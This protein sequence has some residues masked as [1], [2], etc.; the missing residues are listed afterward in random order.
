MCFIKQLSKINTVNFRNFMRYPLGC[1]NNLKLWRQVG[2]GSRYPRA[3][4]FHNW[5]IRT[6]WKKNSRYAYLISWQKKIPLYHGSQRCESHFFNA[7]LLIVFVLCQNSPK[8]KFGQ[9]GVL[10]SKNTWTLKSLHSIQC[11]LSS[12]NFN[13]KSARVPVILEQ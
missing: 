2:T 6:K 12:S 3:I 9:I 7:F 4:I 13:V 8:I 10:F 11:K 1:L 5:V